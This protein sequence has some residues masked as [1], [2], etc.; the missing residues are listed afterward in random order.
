MRTWQE[1]TEAY[2]ELLDCEGPVTV[3]SFTFAAS[4]IIKTLDPV[5]Y[6]V[7]LLDWLDAEG[8]EADDLTGPNPL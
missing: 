6:R 1:A 5:A 7:T 2:D 8:I 3:S 4:R